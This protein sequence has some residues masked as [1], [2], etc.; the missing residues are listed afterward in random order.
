MKI[1]IGLGNGEVI[2]GEFNS[3]NECANLMQEC[4][5]NSQF[6]KL[7]RDGEDIYVNPR[8]IKVIQSA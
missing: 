1:S 2:I 8:Q 3:I 4:A 5:V 7:S 6:L